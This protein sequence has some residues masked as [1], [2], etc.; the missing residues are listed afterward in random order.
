MP[1]TKEEN[2]MPKW[3]GCVPVSQ[4]TMSSPPP[5]YV[6][7][8]AAGMMFSPA[9]TYTAIRS[10]PPTRGS[11]TVSVRPPVPPKG[12]YYSPTK[13]WEPASEKDG[14]APGIFVQREW[15]VE[16]G[17]SIEGASQ[18]SED[19]ERGLLRDKRKDKQEYGRW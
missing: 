12:S 8:K 6:D 7:N 13:R 16:R 19:T 2:E 11:D 10:P 17:E 4:I 18:V 1:T 14:A 3:P 5:R 15:D 9:P